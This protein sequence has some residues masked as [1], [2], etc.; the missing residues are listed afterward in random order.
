MM[1]L[2]RATKNPSKYTNRWPFSRPQKTPIKI[3]IDGPFQGC[4]K[5][6]KIHIDGP[7][8]GRKKSFKTTY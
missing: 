2:F 3:H 5:A 1:A 6:L 4:K 8:Q 7:F